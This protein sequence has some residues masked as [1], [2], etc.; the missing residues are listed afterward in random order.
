MSE[1]QNYLPIAQANE[2]V[3]RN[4][5]KDLDDNRGKRL[6]GDLLPVILDTK[7]SI[8]ELFQK[9]SVGERYGV[10]TIIDFRVKGDRAIIEFEDVACMS[11]GGSE[12][13]YQIGA[14]GNVSFST[15]LSSFIS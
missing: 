4:I 5:L 13:E 9:Y 14:D 7:S 8:T 12:L 15:A 6:G 3:F 2:Q 10:F 11:G 1:P